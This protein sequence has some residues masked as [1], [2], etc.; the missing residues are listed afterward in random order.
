MAKTIGN[1]RIR[2]DRRTILAALNMC[3]PGSLDGEELFAVV[4]DG[5]P[6]YA[7]TFLVRDLVYLRDKGYLGVKRIDG[8]VVRAIEIRACKFALTAAGTDVA[9][10]LV[11]D[12][13]LE[14]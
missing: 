11:D 10:Q 7:R 9:N 3:F 12:P 2:R 8:T 14:V 1:S 4:L 5:N 13:T 6:E